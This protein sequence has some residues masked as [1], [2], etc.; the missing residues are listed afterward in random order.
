MYGDRG[1]AALFQCR[2]EPDDRRAA[3][4]SKADAKNRGIAI[5]G[6]G[7][8][9]LRINCPGLL[10]SDHA[11]SDRAPV[12]IEPLPQLLHEHG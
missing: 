8:A 6:D 2:G 3:G 5:S 12:I 9:Q 4:A 10:R 1:H 7:R 11:R